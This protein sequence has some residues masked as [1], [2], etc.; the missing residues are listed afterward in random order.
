MTSTRARS[1]VRLTIHPPNRQTHRDLPSPTPHA[2]HSTAEM[3][4]TRARSAVRLTIHPPTVRPQ[5]SALSHSTRMSLPLQK[6][7]VPEPE[8]LVQAD[9]PPTHRQTTE[10]CPLPLHTQVTPLQKWLVAEPE[11]LSAWP[12]THPLS[13]H[14][15][16]PSPTPHRNVTPLQK[17]L[18][19]RAR[20]AVR[21]TLHPPTVRP[22]RSA[23]SHST[24]QVTPLQKWL[25]AE[26]EALLAEHPPTHCQT[27]EICP[28]PLH[29][30][31]TPLQKWTWP[32]EFIWAENWIYSAAWLLDFPLGH[33]ITV[34]F[35]REVTGRNWSQKG[36]VR[37]DDPKMIH[38]PAYPGIASQTK[39]TDRLFL[40]PTSG[41]TMQSRLKGPVIMAVKLNELPLMTFGQLLQWQRNF[42]CIPFC[43]KCYWVDSNRFTDK[44][45]W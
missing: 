23:L 43:G 44:H 2:C 35:T 18:V 20:S 39:R 21:L 40:K 12:S 11:A 9:P 37:S 1:A 19:P 33:I 25:V 45:D 32:P 29:T 16:L 15:D 38:S 24:T 10:I 42:L 6:G 14:R 41:K 17:G 4:S 34:L 7:L 28:L 36:A 22:Q 30:H 8:A 27:T 3:T 31:V 26:P 13:D 5:R